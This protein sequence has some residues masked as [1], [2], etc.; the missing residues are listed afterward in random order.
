MRSD[1]NTPAEYIAELPKERQAVVKKL[2]QVLRKNLPKGFKE[3]MGHGMLAYVVP[4]QLFP[5]GYHCD[6]KEPLPFINLA[7]QKQYVSLYH[8]GLYD[9]PLLAW[10]KREWPR[11]SAAKLDV[12]K[13]CLRLKRLEDIPYE[14]IG[15][16]AT[17]M[18][19]D[20]WIATYEAATG[21]RAKRPRARTQRA[22]E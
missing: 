18:T 10:L 5:A 2:R 9:G 8:M 17:K 15:E 1:A 7:S 22:K 19:P 6:P 4:H 20:E 14:L 3:T 16:L 11:H 13:C 12:G 21:P